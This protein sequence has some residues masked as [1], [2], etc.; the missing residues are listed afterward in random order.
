MA[1]YY[2][3]KKT[4]NEVL[5]TRE[6]GISKNNEKERQE[7]DVQKYKDTESENIKEYRQGYEDISSKNNK[8]ERQENDVQKYRDTESENNIKEYRQRYGDTNPEDV[9]KNI[10]KENREVTKEKLDERYNQKGQR[11]HK[12]T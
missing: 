2:F 1:D 7:N 6:E 8:K 5:H 9:K 3:D 4:R 12:P 11:N 10:N